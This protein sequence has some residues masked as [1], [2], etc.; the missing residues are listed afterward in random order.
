MNSW[1]LWS[2]SLRPLKDWRMLLLLFFVSTIVAL[3]LVGFLDAHYSDAFSNRVA[4]VDVLTNRQPAAGLYIAAFLDQE[5]VGVGLVPLL[6]FGVVMT[7][8]TQLFLSGGIVVW[9]GRE[10]RPFL[11]SFYQ[12]CGRNVKH[13]LKLTFAFLLQ[14]FFVVG[15]WFAVSFGIAA[16]LDEKQIAGGASFVRMVGLIGGLLLFG[17]LRM[18]T[19][20]ARATPRVVEWMPAFDAWLSGWRWFWRNRVRTLALFLAQF[21]IGGS[22]LLALNAWEWSIDATSG[23]KVMLVFLIAQVAIVTRCAVRLASWGGI[24]RFVEVQW[25]RDQEEKKHRELQEQWERE[26]RWREEQ[27]RQEEARA[28]AEAAAAAAA[29]AEAVPSEPASAEEAGDVTQVVR[30]SNFP[31]AT[32]EAPLEIPEAEDFSLHTVEQPMPEKV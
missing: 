32:I 30:L 25:Q 21:L 15:S 13:N 5:R 24:T 12:A 20:F 16:L 10:P 3:P 7:F 8:L 2:H 29:A 26:R 17:M 14:A 6:M 22:I 28:A 4:A 18:T 9:N 31:T 1:K 11:S 23:S 19:D 27:R